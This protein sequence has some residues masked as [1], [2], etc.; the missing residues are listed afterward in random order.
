MFCQYKL[1]DLETHRTSDQKHGATVRFDDVNVVLV[2]LM[3]SVDLLE[4]LTG[5]PL[6]IEVHDRDRKSAPKSPAAFDEPSDAA[7]S[8]T[9]STGNL[10]KQE[11]NR[12]NPYGVAS[13][14]LS[15]LLLGKRRL[16]LDL[17]IKCS[18]PPQML[19]RRRRTAACGSSTDPMQQ[20]HYFDSKLKV[21]IEISRP[22]NVKS[23]IR[24]LQLYDCPF[25]RIIYLFAYN[26]VS[27]MTKLRQEIL[28]INAAAFNLSSHSQEM[29]EEVLPRYKMNS[30]QRK[31]KDL[32]FVSGFHVLDKKVQIFVLEGLKQKAVRRLWE[33]VPTK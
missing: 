18:P 24:E 27:V 33:N 26:N 7:A 22:L 9:C 31:S 4:L 20:G 6:E 19:S 29:I 12:L 28:R 1:L 3:S 23:D 17:R 10:F 16:Q 8:R 32:D 14:N 30:K 11:T 13:V 5:P 21:R 2:G 25:G 15:E